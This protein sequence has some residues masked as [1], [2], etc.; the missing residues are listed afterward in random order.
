MQ[1]R[2]LSRR[3]VL[4]SAT[5]VAAGAAGVSAVTAAPAAAHQRDHR[6]KKIIARMSVEAK[7]GQLFVPYFYGASATSPSQVDQDRNLKEL[8]VRTVA[9]LIAKY[10]VGGVI[11][12]S[13]WTN[14]LHD[15]HQ[16]AD[17]SN[18]VQR[19]SLALP[20]PVPSLISIDQEHG[21]NVRIGSGATQLPGAMALGA[22]RSLSDARTAGWISGTELAALGI[23]QNFAPVADVNVNPANPIINVRSFG[24]DAREVG[25]MVGAQVTGYQQ[26]GVVACAKHFPGHGDTGEDSH[27]GLPVITHTREEW[28]RIDA[29]PFR[30]AIAAGVDSIMT[31]HLQVPALDPSN[32]PATLSPTIL[33]DVLRGELGFDGVIVTDALNMQGVRTKYGDDRVPVLALK[34]GA[35]QLLFPPSIDVAYNGVLAAVRTGEIT[36]DR[37]DASVLRILR[38]KEKAGLLSGTPFVSR[39]D[40]DRVVGS[41]RHRLTAARIAERTT[42]LLVNEDGALPLRRGRGKLLVVGASPAFPTDDTRTTVPEL[43]KAFDELGYRTTHLATGRTP[44]AAKIDEA[45]AAARGR[46]A[47]VVTTDNVGAT[48]TQR[49]LVSRLLATGVPVVHL[50]V[51]NPYDIAHLGDVPASLASYC[52]TEVELRAAAR[53]IAGRVG[54]RGRL[55]VPV[56]RA[57][58]PSRVLFRTGHGLSY[59][60]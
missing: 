5:A 29:P 50:A 51:R 21:V 16:I 35:D 44:D 10:Q 39:R 56:Q 6:L 1:D 25:R 11:Y 43:A 57:D 37:L 17:L 49:T 59:D 22:G 14:N 45:V 7:I 19:A 46:D 32:E 27:T 15:P 48:S 58:D 60:D 26:A 55:P 54:P 12:F 30:A 47:V 41:R 42:T 36:E 2:S 3:T 4:A 31:A 34:A 8:G 28:E 52:W 18:G 40:V 9:E 20:V 24:A 33:Q 38:V 53:V 23:H 13:G